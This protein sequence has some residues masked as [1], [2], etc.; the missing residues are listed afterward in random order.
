MTGYEVGLRVL[1]AVPLGLL[2]GSF[3]TVAIHRLP[4]GGS[5]R[6]PRSRC[7]HCG[8]RIRTADALPLVSWLLLRGRCRSCR[9]RISPVSPLTELIGACGGAVVFYVYGMLTGDDDPATEETGQSQQADPA[10]DDEDDTGDDDDEAGGD[11]DDEDRQDADG[12][13]DADDEEGDREPLPDNDNP[14][15]QTEQTNS[16]K[17]NGPDDITPNRH[18][19]QQNARKRLVATMRNLKKQKQRLK[20]AQD[21]LQIR[22]SKILNTAARYGD[23]HPSKSYPKRKLLPEFDEEAL[24]PPQLKNKTAIR[25]DR[26]PRGQHRAANDAAHKPVR[27]PPRMRIKGTAQ[28]DPSMDHVSALQHT[29]QHNKH[30]KNEVHPE[31]GVPHTPYVSPLRCWIMNFQRDSNP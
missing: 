14:D 6:H 31:T 1:I 30:P 26:R 29:T 9:A 16:I 15:N 3:L 8:A 20:A 2:F 4:A 23:N 10:A 13:D 18:P 11:D 21:T 25:S 19:E 28:P 17:D 5:L 27:D 7:P 12:E 22:C 24:D